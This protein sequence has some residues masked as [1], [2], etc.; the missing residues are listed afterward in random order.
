MKY[1][2]IFK[3]PC[4]AGVMMIFGCSLTSSCTEDEV[5]TGDINTN[6]YESSNELLG[7]LTDS[8]GKHM[9]SNIEFRSSGELSLFL[10]LTKEASSNC[11]I[12]IT[13]DESVLEEY[14]AKNSSSYELFP[15]T[16]VTLPENPTI[17]VET[18]KQQSSPL[19]VAFTSNGQLSA[20]S[21]YVIPLRIT[22]TSGNVKLAQGEDTRLIFITDRTGIPD[23]NKENG[24]KILS[25]M[26]VNDTNPLNN[27]S[28]TLKNSG[29]L[30]VDVLIMF[31]G[32]M[33]YDRETG[34]VTMKYNNNIQALLNGYDHYLKP[35]KDRGMKVIMGILPDHDGSGLCNLAPETCEEF[36]L[37][38]KAMCDAYNLDGVFLDEEYADYNDYDLYLNVPGFVRPTASACS[39]LVYEIHKLQPEKDIIVYAY[40]TIY[41]LPSINVDGRTINSVQC[42]TYAVHAYGRSGNLS[43]SYPGLPKTNMGMFSQEYTGRFFASESNLQRMV[44]DGYKTHM[45]FAMDPNRGNFTYQQL[46]SMQSIAKIVYNDELVFDGKKYPKDWD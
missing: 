28:F 37:E 26:E 46:P 15:K 33:K 41:S 43:S 44:D 17:K 13:Y 18:G 1:T 25:C 32:N 45:I 21:K 42:I 35:L 12:S 3:L 30:L 6:R 14:N 24:F 22:V 31:S 36:A 9:S 38:I 27:L 39:R 11:G 19:P 40:S 29:K 5:M 8:Q 10:N 4:I 23:C 20:D 2:N 16:Q 7:Y 34:H